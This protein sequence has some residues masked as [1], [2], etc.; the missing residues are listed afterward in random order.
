MPCTP[1]AAVF[2]HAAL[3]LSAK[4]QQGKASLKNKLKTAKN[5]LNRL[6]RGTST[7]V[8]MTS[9]SRRMPLHPSAVTTTAPDLAAL[10]KG[11]P[12]VSPMSI[13]FGVDACVLVL[14]EAALLGIDSE[15]VCRTETDTSTTAPV[16]EAP[17]PSAATP[18]VLSKRQK[19]RTRAKAAAAKKTQ[20]DDTVYASMPAIRCASS[21][22]SSAG[23]STGSSST[24]RMNT[25]AAKMKTHIKSKQSQA[26]KAL[27]AA[28]HAHARQQR[29]YD[30]TRPASKVA[31]SSTRR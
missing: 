30:K 9:S 20:Q 2:A 1:T 19:Q 24:S 4:V 28:S 8:T 14:V 22:A 27:W 13:M 7:T 6:I 31:P 10:S 15:T 25:Q 18:C 29:Y 5:T 26:G 21:A 12:P 3:R 17:T 11:G 16:V 23:S